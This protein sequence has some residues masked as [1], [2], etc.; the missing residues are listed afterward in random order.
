M[1]ISTSRSNWVQPT[2]SFLDHV[3]ELFKSYPTDTCVIINATGATLV[4][5]LIHLS[6]KVPT[7]KH[8]IEWYNPVGPYTTPLLVHRYRQRLEA[9]RVPQIALSGISQVYIGMAPVLKPGNC[10]RLEPF[11]FLDVVMV[12]AQIKI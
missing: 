6:L 8:R 5:Q 3:H 9:I 11:S 7:T 10:E 2:G 1:S 12:A 4:Q